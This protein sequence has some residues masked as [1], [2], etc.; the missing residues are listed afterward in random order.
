MCLLLANQ[1][2]EPFGYGDGIHRSWDRPLSRERKRGSLIE[3]RA[4]M[5][6][7]LRDCTANDLS[8]KRRCGVSCHAN[9]GPD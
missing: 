8:E 4:R 1:A 2:S 6:D 7:L 9:L 3:S 5:K